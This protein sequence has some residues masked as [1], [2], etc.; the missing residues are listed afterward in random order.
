MTEK[1]DAPKV[2]RRSTLQIATPEIQGDD[3]WVE[4]VV[5]T[6]GERLSLPASIIKNELIK[7]RV[8][9]WNWVDKAGDPLPQPDGT[10]EMINVLTT[11]EVAALFDV[12]IG[13]P[14]VDDL[15]N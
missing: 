1:A 8:I 3:S 12:V 2:A 13:F 14:T 15:K 11:F 5:F 4:V 6:V 9:G 10:D 7:E